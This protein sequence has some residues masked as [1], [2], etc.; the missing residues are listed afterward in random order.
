MRAFL[1][2]EPEAVGLSE[3][4][5]HDLRLLDRLLGRVLESQGQSGLIDMARRLVALGNP[6]PKGMIE[7][8]PELADPTRLRDL[9][10]A[11][12]VLFQ[13]LN[14]AE[15]KE[16]VRAN[17][18]RGENRRESIRDAVLELKRRGVSAP[19]MRDLLA[20]IEI[21]PTLTAHPTEAKRKAVLDKL[22]EIARLLAE[23]AQPP[24]L[25]ET[26]NAVPAQTR[27]EQTLTTLWQ[28]DEMRAT[29]LTVEEE[30]RNALYFFD[31]TIM[32]CVPALH[33][34]LE[35]ALA[36][37]YP[38]ASIP[39]PTLLTY[40]SWVG[41][42][43]DG[44]PSVTADVTW[45]TLIR[46]RIAALERYLRQAEQLR[47]EHTFSS[48]LGGISDELRES[49]AQDDARSPLPGEYRT[50]YAE[51]PYV[52]KWLSIEHRLADT[53][54][55]AHALLEHRSEPDGVPYQ[56]ADELLHDLR[57]IRA[58]LRDHQAEIV[59][60]EGPLPHFIRQVEAFGFHLAAL[61][62]RQHS[63]EHARALTEI[64]RL[65]LV[66][67]DAE[68]YDQLPEA[69]KREV[70]KKELRNPRPLLPHHAE[71][72]ETSRNVLRVFQVIARAHRELGPACIQAYIVSMAHE[73]S[74]LLEIQVLAKEAGLDAQVDL[75]PLFETIDDLH[76][77]SDLLREILATEEYQTYLD[78]RGGR[79]EIMLG[80]SD[81]SKDG[82][83]LAA[84]WALQ[85]TLADLAQ[86]QDE[87]G[88]PV[89]LFHGRGG[90]VG[91]G[92]G[93]ANRAILSQPS[94]SFRGR[95]RFTEQGEVISFR[96]SL[97]PIA[98]RHLEQIVSAVLTAS[99]TSL[100]RFRPADQ[101]GLEAKYAPAMAEMEAESK[102]A[103]RRLVYENP[104][105]WKFYTHATPIEHIA[106][107]PIAS[108]PVYRPGQAI[109]GIEGLRAIPWNFAWVQNRATLV[110][111]YGLGSALQR[112][113]ANQPGLVRQMH[114][115][116]PFF[117]NVVANAQLELSRAHLPTARL[118][119]DRVPETEIRGIQTEIEEE[120]NR[121]TR[122]ILAATGQSSWM[123]NAHVVYRTIQFRNPAVTPLSLMQLYAMDR[124]PHLTEEERAGPWR[125][126]MLQTIAGLA[127][128]MQST[129]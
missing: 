28:T 7:A 93:R 70:L 102:A 49:L 119:A 34:D 46:H 20:G 17:R 126:A 113:E 123:E 1:N 72:S 114:Q 79:Q 71:L 42:D 56:R 43:R 59:A 11:F 98:H 100:A 21:V 45:E 124:W 69:R 118:Y 80:Y 83:F 125:E 10:R 94:G 60:E 41:G 48:K 14:L 110:G 77:S 90:T 97:L 106:L 73:V 47:R 44:N 9:A 35:S 36:E 108:R 120:Y 127:A 67:T 29:R 68:P 91:R 6:T 129:G 13:L 3:P 65:A 27:L 84:N 88:V 86:V 74:D 87:T 95:I 58:S 78:R 23:A 112:M 31:R 128:A 81:S 38:D 89:R 54:A 18:A 109:S 33:R 104:C 92:G 62:V 64:F 66:L 55:H 76:R 75:V 16:I 117:R 50:R 22:Q 115:E 32:D 5:C 96:Y 25:Q 19:E 57:V 105:F 12:T 24:A 116:W 101:S 51:E 26:L 82:G 107:L 30:V 40:R 121:A 39:V 85:S 8:V 15:Q 37:A 53:L 2:L 61:D 99:V 63:D 52:R 103:Y 4:L 122:A 111:W